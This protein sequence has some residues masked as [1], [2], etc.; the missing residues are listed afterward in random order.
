MS[1]IRHFITHFQKLYAS[2]ELKKNRHSK[3]PLSYKTDL[4]A[5]CSTINSAMK[6]SHSRDILSPDLLEENEYECSFDKSIMNIG[7]F[8][9]TTGIKKVCVAHL[10]DS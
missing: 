1:H 5:Y 6:F 3:I 10:C 2:N 9:K 7:T 4:E 8:K